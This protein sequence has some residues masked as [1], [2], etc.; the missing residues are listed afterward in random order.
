M[1]IFHDKGTNNIIGA[2]HLCVGEVLS[3]GWSFVVC[4]EDEVMQKCLI[5][6][7]KFPVQ[8]AYLPRQEWGA[9]VLLEAVFPIAASSLSLASSLYVDSTPG[10][11]TQ[12]SHLAHMCTCQ[13]NLAYIFYMAAISFFPIVTFSVCMVDHGAFIF[14]TDIH[15]YLTYAHITKI[16]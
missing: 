11:F 2:V 1:Y 13:V 3:W 8:E 5:C 9:I 12:T 14:H 7:W 10:L 16:L 6:A 4:E 15:W